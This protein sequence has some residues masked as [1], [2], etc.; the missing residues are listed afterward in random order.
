MS[1]HIQLYKQ[2]FDKS[3][4]EIKRLLTVGDSVALVGNSGILSDSGYGGGIDDHDYVVRFNAAPVEGYEEDIGSKTTH[5]FLNVLLQRGG[6][7]SHTTGTPKNFIEEIR[8]ETV[9]LKSTRARL[10]REAKAAI[11]SSCSVLAIQRRTYREFYSKVFEVFFD[12]HYSSSNLSLGLQGC[13]IFLPLVNRMDL[14]GFNAYSSDN[15]S[16]Y[17]YW[18]DFTKDDQGPHNYKRERNLLEQLENISG[19][20][21]HE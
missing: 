5:R 1:I 3:L 18:E 6:T 20:E 2:L 14:Y 4:S 17:H 21:V 8:N 12:E 15:I 11:D 13:F 7:L 10:Q 9:I 16:N 19:V